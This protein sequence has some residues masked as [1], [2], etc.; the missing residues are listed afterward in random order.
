MISAPASAQAPSEARARLEDCVNQ[1]LTILNSREFHE[2]GTKEAALDEIDG[3]I[4]TIFDFEQFSARTVGIRWKAF[5]PE[6][7]KN[8]QEAFGQLLRATY[9]DKLKAY[10][11]EKVIF[12]G[13]TASKKGDKVAIAT[14]V[15]M[16]D[17][18]TV[19]VIYKLLVQNGRW[20]VYDVVI[21]GLSLVQNYRTQFQDVLAT[22]TP[23]QLIERVQSQ[24]K[25]LRES[26]NNP[27]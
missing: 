7:K 17:K 12:T 16:K 19:P 13:E 22:Q 3:V 21:E 10:S 26:A 11:G 24:T 5:T 4:R 23:E 1:I 6:Q 15:E 8:F 20:V 27:Q 14:L 18:K 9:L 2:E 25:K